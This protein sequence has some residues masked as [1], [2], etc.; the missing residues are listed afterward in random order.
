MTSSTAQKNAEGKETSKLLER[1]RSLVLANADDKVTTVRLVLGDQLDT[2][3]TWFK[4]KDPS[5][6]YVLAELVD[7]VSYVRHHIIKISGFLLAMENF[8]SEIAKKG[9]RVMHL[10]LDETRGFNGVT[11]LVE[12]ICDFFEPYVFE[13]QVPDEY[14]LS[15]KLKKLDLGGIKLKC[16]E[17]NHFYLNREQIEAYPMGD[18]P[19]VME[20]FYRKIRKSENILMNGS[21]PEGGV[22]NLDQ[23]NR[24]KLSKKV[25]GYIPNPLCFNNNVEHIIVRLER[26]KI[27]FLGKPSTSIDLP[28]NIKQAKKLVEYFCKNSLPF[29]GTYQ[30]AMTLNGA[31]RW[32]LFH[33]RISFALNTK[34]IS[35]RFVVSQALSFYEKSNGA[36]SLAQ[37]EGFVRQIIGWREFCR[38]VYWKYMPEYK[39]KNSLLFKDKIPQF[40]WT[41][42]TKMRCVG[43]VVT[44]SL[45]YSYAH[46]IQRLMVT[47]NFLLLSGVDPKDVDNWYLGVYADAIEWV[48][49]PNTRGMSQFADGGIMATK[50]YVSSGNYINKMSDYCSACHYDIKEKTS[51]RSCPFNSLYWGFLDANRKILGKNFRLGM[52]YKLWD[53]LAKSDKKRIINRANY[54]RHNIENL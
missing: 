37:I 52:V 36:I 34:I 32:A 22:W 12:F 7:E 2:N 14:R 33:S 41:G 27:K 49:L 13:Y 15:K 4:K 10:N 51:D 31:N 23:Q 26:H 47:G 54:L 42:K 5:T 24:Q 39:K 50:P 35:P 6:L 9:H 29:F 30:D 19:L 20:N 18:K 43:E 25:M 44:Q 17:D 38:L 1:F 53:R 46:H 21:T 16:I 48:Q 3:H 28:V 45:E 11:S 8:A 40:F